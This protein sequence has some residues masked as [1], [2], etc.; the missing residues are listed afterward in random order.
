MENDDRIDEY[1][2]RIEVNR[3]IN[4][5]NEE[6]LNQLHIGHLTHIPFETFDLIDLKEI[7]I[8]L[9]YI[10][11]R[12]VYQNRGGICYQLNGLFAFILKYFNYNVQ[13]IPCGVY[14]EAKNEYMKDY[15]HVSLYVTLDKATN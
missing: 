2:K 15:S 11:N 7:N 8:S 4:G 12:L 14:I 1:L 5:P 3:P 9:D 10:F 6:Y 13:F